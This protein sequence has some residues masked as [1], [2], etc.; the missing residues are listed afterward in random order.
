MH[1]KIGLEK[2]LLTFPSY[3]L[4]TNELHPS[5]D[6]TTILG[7]A[8]FQRSPHFA[9]YIKVQGASMVFINYFSYFLILATPLSIAALAAASATAD[10]SLLSK[11]AGSI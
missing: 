5:P 4:L 7:E 11:A 1:K 9:L 10:L 2:A 8:L 6:E 3:V